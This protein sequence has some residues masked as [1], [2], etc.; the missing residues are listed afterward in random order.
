MS[1]DVA[2]LLMIVVWI[3]LELRMLLRM[4]PTA[5]SDNQRDRGTLVLVIVAVVIALGGGAWLSYAGIGAWPAPWLPATRWIGVALMLIGN[6]IRQAA[7]ITLGRYFTV[8]VA[9]RADHKL[10]DWG[11]YKHVRHPSY[12]GGIIAILGLALGSGGWLPGLVLT[13]PIFAAIARRVAVEEQA[14]AE[15]FGPAYH[16]WCKRT[17]RLFPRL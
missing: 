8:A 14:M 4:R 9:I 6:A 12:T 15:A 5:T 16:D 2:F 1:A 3:G 10:V 7:V 17:N 11:L 13:V